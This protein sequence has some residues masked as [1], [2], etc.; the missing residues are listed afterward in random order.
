MKVVLV[1]GGFDPLHSG[2]I[3]YFKS[4]KE[5]GDHL[6]VGVNSDAW[7]TRKKGRPFM[8]FE[9]RAA[10]IKELACVDEVIAFNDDDDS[11]C[12]AIGL[13]LSTKATKWKLVF[14]NGGDRTNTTTPEYKLYGDHPDVTF[15]FGV[16]GEDKKN[17]SSWILKEWS[18]PTTKRAWGRYTVLDSGEGWATKK[19][20]FDAG[21][22]LSDQ[23][24]FKRSEHWHVV[25]GTIVMALEYANGDSECKT[26]RSGDSIDIPVLTWH[27]AIN[28]GD[29]T[30]KVIEVWMGNELTEEDIERRD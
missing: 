16:G 18:Q 4:A 13:V 12:N 25:E 15:A 26:Y 11:A 20:A 19:L 8:P 17:S 1:T 21:K 22:S 2:H 5:L 6:V 30:A 28:V 29:E 10:I 24:H 9:E 7:L 23:R 14:A 3:E 27:K